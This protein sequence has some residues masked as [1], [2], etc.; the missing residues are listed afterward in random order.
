MKRLHANAPGLKHLAFFEA[1]GEGP[2]SSPTHR[3]A[4]AGL[5]TLRL[6]DHW[7]LAGASMVEPES[8]SVRSVRQAIMT[9]PANDPQREVLLGLVNTMQTLREVD[10]QPLLPR[11]FAYAGI[12]ERRGELEMA[13]DVY[14]S[15]V[16][17][18][19]EEYDPD[20]IIDSHM[21]L[22][23]CHRYLGALPIAERAYLSAG[24]IANR[25]GEPARVLRSEI[26]LANVAMVRG[27]LPKAEE[28]L[29]AA[30][31]RSDEL[32][33]GEEHAAALHSR[34][35]VA[36]RRGHID[37]AVCFAFDALRRT[38]IPRER[39][40]MLGDVGA[41][42]I[43]L[44]RFDAARDALMILEATTTDQVVR[45]NARVNLVVLGA[46]SGDRDLFD[47]WR[48]ELAGAELAAETTANFMIE[49]ARGLRRFGEPR[50]ATKLLES[51]LAF[52]RERGLN[53]ALFEAEGLL[54]QREV[55]GAEAT[56]GGIHA[57]SHDPTAHVAR[58]LRQM[59]AALA[60]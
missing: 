44:E 47:R 31:V 6:V 11:V 19:S 4:K 45:T 43:V 21:R 12:L 42:L 60:A 7:V 3:A 50:E 28:M 10:L 20:L 33:L 15:V 59:A 26:G 9:I 49:S 37:Q 25:V 57:M 53:R 1:L 36:Q 39:D 17:L 16:R 13:A 35:I 38:T 27:D 32:G 55:V 56:S 46:R 41:F 29:T 18:G 58:E 8:V 2:E 30:A 51:A 5:L 23:Y 14:E 34:A 24:R 52:A 48:S 40:R 22:G 54:G